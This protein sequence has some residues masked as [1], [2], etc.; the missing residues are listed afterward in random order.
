MQKQKCKAHSVSHHLQVSHN[1]CFVQPM[2]MPYIE[3]P[4]MDWT[5]TDSLYH[6]FLKWKLKC[7][8]ILDCELAMLPKFM[9]CNKVIVWRWNFGMN[10]YVLWCLPTEDLSLQVIWAKYEDL[11][12]LQTDEFRARFDLLT[13]FRWSNWSVDEWYNAVQAQVSLAKH[14]PETASILH[15]DIF[16]FF[17]KDE[18]FASKTINDSKTDLDRFLASKVRQLAKKMESSKSTTRHIKQVASD[19]QVAQVNLMRHQ[20]TDLPP[21]KSKQKQHAHKSKSKGQKRYSSEHKNQ[22]PPYKKK[23]WSFCLQV[24]I[25]G[26]QA[27]AKF[28]TPHQ[29]ITNF[30]DRLKPH[31]KRNQYLRA[32]LDTCADVNIMPA[33]VYKLM[34]QDPDCKKLASSRSLR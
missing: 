23:I 2:V 27:S 29:L 1:F 19:P 13:S 9:K 3:G 32:R 34:F 12:K 22:R 30:E 10:Q 18:E 33:S 24:Q 20:R 16:W 6:S 21:S 25:Q 17:L 31:H 5:V 4:K 26:K 7:E 8:N 14:P 15:R 11:C 28:P